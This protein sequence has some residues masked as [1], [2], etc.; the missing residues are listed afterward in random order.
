MKKLR[1]LSPDLAHVPNALPAFMLKADR[2]LPYRWWTRLSDHSAGRRD[3]TQ[4]ETI[5]SDA[6]VASS[7]WLQ[8]QLAECANAIAV[9]RTRTEALVAVLDHELAAM[10]AA[11]D[12]HE[13][14]LADLSAKLRELIAEPVND[15]AIGPGGPYSTPQ[16]RLRRNQDQRAAELSSLRNAIQTTEST[17]RELARRIGQLQQDRRSHWVVLQERSRQ[18]VELTQRR[19]ATYT[20]GLELRRKGIVFTAPTVTAP[21]WVSAELGTGGLEDG[22]IAPITRLPQAI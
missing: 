22:P 9:G 2:P 15:A 7:P 16:E 1:A 4:S 19:V 5:S 12:Q 13:A 17:T 3:R 8:R 18:L 20:R 6:P 10:L 21:H 11:V 14:A